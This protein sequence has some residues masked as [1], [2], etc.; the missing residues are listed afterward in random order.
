[1]VDAEAASRRSDSLVEGG[2]DDLEL[3]GIPSVI[4][5]EAGERDPLLL[6]DKIISE[7]DIEGIRQ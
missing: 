4:S 3:M 6:R 5:R 7:A 1:M 2:P